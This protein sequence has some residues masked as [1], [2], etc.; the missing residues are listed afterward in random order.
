MN[1]SDPMYKMVVEPIME[2]IMEANEIG[3][4]YAERYIRDTVDSAVADETYH[5]GIEIVAL[6]ERINELEGEIDSLIMTVAAMTE[7]DNN[8]SW[9]SRLLGR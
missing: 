2:R 4:E 1:L 9:L 5:M 3:R 6:T 7:Q 8:K